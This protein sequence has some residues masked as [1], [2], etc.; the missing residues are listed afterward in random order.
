MQVREDNMVSEKARKLILSTEGLDQPSKWPGGASGVTIGIGYDL[1][2][3]KEEEF[4]KDWSSYLTEEEIE[5]LATVIGKKGKD[6]EEIADQFSD[7]SIKRSDAETVFNEKSLPK[8]EEMT[9]RAFP[10]FDDLPADAQGALVSL[11]FNRGSS[12]KGDGRIEMR[13]IRDLVPKGDLQGIADEIRKMK[14]LWIGKGL[15]GLLERRDKEAK[16]VEDCIVPVDIVGLQ[17]ADPDWKPASGGN[18]SGGI[19]GMIMSLLKSI[20]GG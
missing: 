17:G 8:Y 5:K 16:L 6:A 9:R 3:M 12:M 10:G 7:I 18:S 20:F 19:F 4:R 11:V 13:A 14:R 1:G 15:D 2:Y